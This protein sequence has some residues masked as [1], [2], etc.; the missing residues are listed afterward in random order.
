[1]TFITACVAVQYDPNYGHDITVVGVTLCLWAANS[2]Q[3]SCR[4]RSHFVLSTVLCS[5]LHPYPT[6]RLQE[7]E[8]AAHS[9]SESDTVGL[10]VLLT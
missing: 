5:G 4:L 2:A 10:K 8:S 6:S 7:N 3:N 1:M 9:W